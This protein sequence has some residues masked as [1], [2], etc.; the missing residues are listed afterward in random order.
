[1]VRAAR[2]ASDGLFPLGSSSL[3]HDATLAQIGA[4]HDCAATAVALAWVMLEFF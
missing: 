2:Y 4:T 3:V 1:M